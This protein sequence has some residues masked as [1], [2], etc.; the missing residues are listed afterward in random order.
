MSESLN[1]LAKTPFLQYVEP[2]NFQRQP[3]SPHSLALFAAIATV[4]DQE[5][6]NTN[7]RL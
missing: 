5:S 3:Q 7:E 1:T 4:R 2:H 6:S